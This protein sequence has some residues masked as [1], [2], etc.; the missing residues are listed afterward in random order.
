MCVCRRLD[1]I[2]AKLGG[3]AEAARQVG[4]LVSHVGA[5][6]ATIHDLYEVQ[7]P[8]SSRRLPQ[9]ALAASCCSV[10]PLACSTGY[11]QPVHRCHA[12]YL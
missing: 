7:L 11:S 6:L 8:S 2:I 4:R 10:L 1:D 12:Q 9:S 5:Q 3:D